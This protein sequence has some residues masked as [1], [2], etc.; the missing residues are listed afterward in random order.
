MQHA[1]RFCRSRFPLTSVLF[2]TTLIAGLA[3]YILWIRVR[4]RHIEFPLATDIS[5]NTIAGLTFSRVVDGNRVT[6]IQNSDFFTAFLDDVAR[7]THHVHLETFLWADGLVSDRVVEGLTAKAREKVEVR[8]LVDHRGGITTSPSVWAALR[9][10]GV[11]FRVYHRARLRELGWYN[12]RD[13]RKIVVVDGR[14]GYTFGHGIADMWS[15]DGWRDTAAR[16]EGPVVNDLQSAFLDNWLKVTRRALVDDAYFPRIEPQGTTPI[17]VVWAAPPET[18]SAVQRLYFL[19][20]A[21]AKRELILQN[22]YFIPDRHAVRLCAEAVARGVKVRLMLPTSE[23]SDFPIVQH[24]SH[25]YYGPL[26]RAGATIHEY[27]ES[28][29]HQK[30]MIVDR[31]WCTIGSANFDPRSFN[32]NDEITVAIYDPAVAE[33]LARAFEADLPFTNEWTLQRWMSRTMWHRMRDR[34]SVLMKRQL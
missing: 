20:I 33:E 32:I 1:R 21:S 18:T 17:S 28:G 5:P 25:F 15:G 6:I 12:N 30:V 8:V 19:A 11:D 16:I 22:P 29:I 14:V 31:R 9:R 10:A 3:L 13:H 26:L 2:L 4:R 7:A 34:V 24:A 27:T 23:T